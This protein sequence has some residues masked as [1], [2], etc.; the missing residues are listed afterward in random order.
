[1]DFY[2]VVSPTSCHSD[3]GN[4]IFTPTTSHST[5]A[6]SIQGTNRSVTM[7]QATTQ[8]GDTS[9]SSL[10]SLHRVLGR[11]QADSGSP[12]PCPSTCRICRIKRRVCSAVSKCKRAISVLRV[13]CPIRKEPV[14][15]STPLPVYS[16]SQYNVGFVSPPRSPAQ[17]RQASLIYESSPWTDESVYSSSEEQS[18]RSSRPADVLA[19][20]DYWRLAT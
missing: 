19:A 11:P 18:L 12:V 1:M 4:S 17:S 2:N 14:R 15:Y 10:P 7:S 13:R 5:A 3:S 8:M 20:D 16:V 6:T 9:N